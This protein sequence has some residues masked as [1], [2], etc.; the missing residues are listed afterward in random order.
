MIWDSHF[1]ERYGGVNYK[2][3][4]DRPDKF[5]MLKQWQ[6]TDQKVVFAAFERINY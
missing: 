2:Y 1:A 3:F 5:L 4:E 6:S